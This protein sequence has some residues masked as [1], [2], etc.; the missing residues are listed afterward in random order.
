[1]LKERK[2]EGVALAW[3]N[4]RNHFLQ[5]NYRGAEV[6]KKKDKRKCKWCLAVSRSVED[7]KL[8]VCYVLR[9]KTRVT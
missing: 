8:A 6:G 2:L 9:D 5:A 7:K 3:E 4:L 1:M